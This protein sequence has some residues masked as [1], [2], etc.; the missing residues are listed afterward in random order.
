MSKVLLSSEVST[1]DKLTEVSDR[2]ALLWTWLLTHV[3][4]W[5]QMDGSPGTVEA[6]VVPRR[7]WG[8][9]KV[10]SIL[11]EL[12]DIG[13]IQIYTPGVS[14]QKNDAG[15]SYKY[16]SQLTIIKNWEKFQRLDRRSKT[17][18]FPMP[19]EAQT[20]SS[21]K[22][23]EIPGNSCERKGKERNR[24][25]RINTIDHFPKKK[26]KNDRHSYPQAFEL[27]WEVY[28]RKVGKGACFK[29]WQ[30]AVAS[31]TTNE[32]FISAINSQ[33]PYWKDPEFIPHP[34]TWLNQR[35]W[36]DE[37]DKGGINDGNGE[38]TES[39]TEHFYPKSGKSPAGG[40]ISGD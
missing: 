4:S 34:A 29:S 6:R 27:F 40:D 25:E 21:G 3:N 15:E 7:R 9:N 33:A 1:S 30:K 12:H 18:E 35:R 38:R 31:G 14:G 13:L 20:A 39:I 11:N 24:K 22:I 32:Q 16:P 17:P 19:C 37:P 28:P 10:A 5:G 23:P 36:E 26:R 2:A 8:I